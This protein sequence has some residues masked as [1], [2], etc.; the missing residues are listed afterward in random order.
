MKRWSTKRTA[1]Q[2]IKAIEALGFE[3]TVRGYDLPGESLYITVDADAVVRVSNHS[4]PAWGGYDICKG[5]HHGESDYCIDPV[6]GSIAGL[7]QFLI[8]R[9][10]TWNLPFEAARN[11]DEAEGLGC[12]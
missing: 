10:N 12:S 2:A 9:H 8:A 7:Q 11:L 6:H 1:R 3:F 4:Q 5:R